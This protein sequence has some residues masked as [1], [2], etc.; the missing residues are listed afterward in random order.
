MVR[1]LDDLPDLDDPIWRHTTGI[2]KL[3]DLHHHLL[4]TIVD[5]A[6]ADRENL[7]QGWLDAFGDQLT[8]D[9]TTL[10]T[11][12]ANAKPRFDQL[13]SW[14]RLFGED[15]NDAEE[16]TT[17]DENAVDIG[18]QPKRSDSIVTLVDA[19]RRT[20]LDLMRRT[21]DSHRADDTDCEAKG[22]ASHDSDELDVSN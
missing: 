17:S 1:L 10:L 14:D 6:I 18:S 9:E 21:S 7:E 20:V 5:L 22:L 13:R 15:D 4:A 8:S 11:R 19:Y 12:A 2:A 16:P 3:H